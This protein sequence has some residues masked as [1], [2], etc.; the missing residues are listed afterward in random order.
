MLDL[1]RPLVIPELAGLGLALKAGDLT[2]HILVTG[3]SGAG[4]SLSVV[5]P[6]LRAMLQWRRD[7]DAG[8]PALLVIDPKRELGEVVA[9][10]APDVVRLDEASTPAVDLFGAVN[11]SDLDAGTVVDRWLAISGSDWSSSRDPFWR[12]AARSLFVDLVGLD[13]ALAAKGRDAADGQLCRASFWRALSHELRSRTLVTD[14]EQRALLRMRAPI[15]RYLT[16]LRLL[17]RSP[18]DGENSSAVRATEV[19]TRCVASYAADVTIPSVSKLSQMASETSMSIVATAVAIAGPLA[20]GVVQA[21]ICFAAVPPSRARSRLDMRTAIRSGAVLLYQP[22]DG[23]EESACISRALK[24]AWYDAVLQGAAL[25]ANG[26]PERLA[27]LVADEFQRAITSVGVS[28]AQYVDR[29]RALGG[30]CLFATQSTSAL[31][32]RLPENA[33]HALRALLNNV[34]LRIV[35]AS[36]DPALPREIESVVPAPPPGFPHL[37]HARPPALFEPGE[38]LW[39][40]PGGY[41]LGRA[42]LKRPYC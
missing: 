36:T 27:L 22:R 32:E 1:S 19:L 11:R 24:A 9:A 37:V 23:G 40:R 4:K 39:V 5:I 15:S 10:Y 28:D 8:R 31:R 20:D 30:G 14:A 2:R 41:G 25:G 12:V 6:V 26:Q 33:D 18:N 29:A 3:G 34:G 17:P 42:V 7:E 35:M 21:R 38:A 16:L 13:L